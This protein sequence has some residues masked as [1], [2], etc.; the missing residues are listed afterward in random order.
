MARYSTSFIL[1]LSLILAI[2]LQSCMTHAAI[3]W[4]RPAK[5]DKDVA[6]AMKSTDSVEV[7]RKRRFFNVFGRTLFLGFEPKKNAKD[8]GFVIYPGTLVTPEAYAPL[9]K[10]IAEQGYRVAVTTPPLSLAA[11]GDLIGDDYAD[12]VIKR[13]RWKNKVNTWTIGGHSQ[14]G[15]IACSYARKN[16]GSKLK[17][18]VLM[19]SYPGNMLGF[20]GDISKT[21]YDV[22]SLYGTLDG[23]ALYEDVVTGAKKL[24]PLGTKFAEID[25]GNHSQF[26]Y[27]E[28][29]QESPG[30]VDGTPTITLAEQQDIIHDNVIELLSKY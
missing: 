17:G 10:R 3:P 28:G 18:V 26:S 4:R 23:I 30:K 5:D 9:A 6:A 8:V 12:L 14:G 11:V 16:V 21:E 13:S 27:A 1:S 20:D 25:G 15:A 7:F 29:I 24:L 2:T 22:V 19:A